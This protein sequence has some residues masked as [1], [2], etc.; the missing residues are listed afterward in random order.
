MVDLLEIPENEDL[1]TDT[2]H[3]DDKVTAALIK[4]NTHPS[5]IKN[6]G[7]ER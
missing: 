5:I 2:T 4:Y 6:K 1:I 7:I 3:I